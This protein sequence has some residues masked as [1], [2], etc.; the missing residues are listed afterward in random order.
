MNSID[1]LRDLAL[2]PID[3]TLK[4]AA[5]WRSASILRRDPYAAQRQI[6]ARLVKQG[7]ESRFGHDHG[8]AE[9]ARLPYEQLYA[10]FRQQVPIRTYTD[11]WRDY[12][13]A[14]VTNL[15]G[16]T[17][18]NIDNFTWPG[19]IPFFCETSG[20][21]APTKYIPF[22][23]EMFA[24]NRYAAIDMI[25][26]YL[27]YQPDS[28]LLRGK[29]LYMAGNTSLTEHGKGVLSGD[30]SAI[31]FAHSPFYLRPFVAPD[32]A[33]AALP[34]GEKLEKMARLLVSE[35]NI[36]AISGVPPWILLL[37]RRTVEL[38]GVEVSKAL[39]Q[40][41]LI[42][43]GGTSLKPYQLEFSSLFGKSSP[44][45][46]E[47]LPSSEA[48]MAYQLA[49]EAQ[50][51]LAPY[52]GTFFE[53]VPLDDLTDSG[54]PAPDATAVPLEG[55]EPGRRYAVILSTCAGL[56]RY[57]IGDTI[58]FTNME[59]L[60]ID[61]TGRDR[62]LDR[63]EEKVTQGEVEEAIARLNQLKGIAISEFMVGPDISARRHLWVLAGS[64][65]N[66]D[67]SI[68]TEYLDMAICQQNT[69]YATFRH[70]GRIAAPQVVV[71]P[72]EAIYSW[73]R[74]VRGKIGGQSKIPH[75]D[76]TLRGDMVQDL[77]TFCLGGKPLPGKPQEAA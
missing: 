62:F 34:W 37:L 27:A 51:R 58:R 66:W 73:S 3:M 31:T 22:S 19:R 12:F 50:M 72:A 5:A 77:A 16:K 49:G 20:T 45:F 10:R 17:S 54:A 32:K 36:R 4:L 63:F 38:A 52:Y 7:A 57:H 68:I 21:T 71:V 55:V 9:L 33:M 74:E 59:T 65:G 48:F 26:A 30:M 29:L 46:L 44:A 76:P 8:F 67:C 13:A 25:A 47:L 24:A 53:F 6:L 28:R 40:L 2:R 75:I 15:T 42:I 23:R 35:K 41:E 18:L 14:G 69:D 70:Q 43:H 61:F 60:F 56:W 64:N 11:F 39:P 1:I